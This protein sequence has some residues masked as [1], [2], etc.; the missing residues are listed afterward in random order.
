MKLN[1]A[2]SLWRNCQIPIHFT[3]IIF[4]G[5]SDIIYRHIISE[6]EITETI[7][8]ISDLFTSVTA[9]FVIIT[10]REIYFWIMLNWTKIR[11]YSVHGVYLLE[12]LVYFGNNLHRKLGLNKIINSVEVL[13]ILW[14]YYYYAYS[15]MQEQAFPHT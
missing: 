11:L 13:Q 9:I 1:F 12:F 3:C 6:L 10:H 5:F 14:K 15:R 4:T 7:L 8:P 2:R